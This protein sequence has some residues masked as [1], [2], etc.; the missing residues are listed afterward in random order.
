[1]KYEI[2]TDEVWPVYS[3]E[4][5]V[6]GIELPDEFV[7]KYHDVMHKYKQIQEKLKECDDDYERKLYRGICEG[8]GRQN[9]EVEPNILNQCDSTPKS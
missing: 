4:N 1:M 5:D 9:S 8:C 6:N 3:I 7:E 2:I